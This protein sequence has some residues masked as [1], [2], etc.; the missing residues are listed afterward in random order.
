MKML[1]LLIL[2]TIM[3]SC[4]LLERRDFS[5]QMDYRF[6]DPIFKPNDDF[7]V[8][9]GDTGKDFDSYNEIVE[10]TPASRN[11]GQDYRYQKSLERELRYLERK[12][13]E[14][15][16]YEYT[17]FRNQL[18]SN[19]EK[20]Y[21]L[22]LNHSEKQDYLSIRKISNRPSSENYREISSFRSSTNIPSTPRNDI[23]LGMT[24]NDALQN[25][26]R[27]FKRDIDGSSELK[28]ERW[29]Y[30]KNGK[31]KYIYFESGRV[32]GWSEQ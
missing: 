16:Y 7:M 28:N 3:T 12:L 15:E 30:Q 27:P 6:D 22:R 25:W 14:N 32:Q 29:A 11:V 8:M 18:G 17:Q 1:N 24:Q 10:R 20:I 4:G 2:L 5:D 26:G 13:T 19:S 9:A 21:F 31:I 23:T